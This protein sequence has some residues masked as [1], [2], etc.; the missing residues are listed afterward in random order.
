[1]TQKETVSYYYIIS[2]DQLREGQFINDEI[3]QIIYIIQFLYL[4][5]SKIVFF[6]MRLI[7]KRLWF[8]LNNFA[9]YFSMQPITNQYVDIWG[10][11][12]HC[13]RQMYIRAAY[14]MMLQI[15]S[16]HV[17]IVKGIK[18]RH[19]NTKNSRASRDYNK[20]VNGLNK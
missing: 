20:G 18:H 7:V 15:V 5:F 6:V 16:R 11:I 9:E 4:I 19:I 3:Y 13:I 10:R 17:W 1:M 8:F 2:I 14:Q 12:R